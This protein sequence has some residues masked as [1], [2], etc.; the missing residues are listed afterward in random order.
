MQTTDLQSGKMIDPNTLLPLRITGGSV[1]VSRT[2][3]RRTCT[4]TT[5]DPSG[6]LPPE[7]VYDLLAPYSTEIR[8]YVGVRYWDAPLPTLLLSGPPADSS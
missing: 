2:T 8:L 1:Q 5:V 4:V 3:I 6:I 7:T